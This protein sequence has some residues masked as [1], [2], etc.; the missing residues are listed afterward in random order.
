MKNKVSVL[1][2]FLALS[3]N[4]Y[5]ANWTKLNENNTS[6]LMLDKQ[7]VLQKDQLKRAWIKIE[8]KTIQKN[9]EVA[10]KEYNLSKLLWFFDCASQKSATSQVFQYLNNELV[11]SVA[12]DSKQAEFIEPVPETDV[13]IAMRYV[14]G[15]DK[16]ADVAAAE[17]PAPALAKPNTPTAKPEEQ[18]VAKSEAA[19]VKP[20]TPA[21]T[22]KPAATKPAEKN[23]AHMHWTYEGKEGPNNWGKLSSDFAT[24]DTGR[25]QSPVNIES[26]LHASLKPFKTLQKFPAKDIVNN[27]HTVQINFKEGNVLV[28]DDVVYQMKLVTFHTPSENTI[29]GEAYP[30]EAHFVHADSKGNS[31]I[32]GVM[33]KEGKA[34][35]A[36]D[37]LWSQMPSEAGDPV[38]LKNT[39]I[40]SELIPQNH[41]YYRFSGSLTAP[42]CSEGVRW[43]LMKSPMT[44]SKDQIETFKHAV[45]HNNNRPVQ[46]LNGR[47]VVE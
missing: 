13:D 31:T 45:H 3:G 27:G 46:P 5:A 29:N 1:F 26:T 44:A 22:V 36:L 25:N 24:C 42:P 14:C 21:P 11:Y 16:T 17:K 41:S 38:T 15:V 20:E 8:F 6:K 47:I 23:T 2:V 18:P 43:L 30:L 9:S 32:I 33:F 34:S 37:K 19:F 35:A 12:I 10:E 28:L 7:S 39:M 40:P 4:S